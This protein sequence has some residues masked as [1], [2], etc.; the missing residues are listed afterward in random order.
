M[1]YVC[2]LQVVMAVAQL[3]QHCV[4]CMCVCML[5]VV[6]AVAQLYHH[7]APRTEVGTVARALMRLLHNHRSVCLCRDGSMN[8]FIIIHISTGSHVT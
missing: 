3:Y 1:L 4:C 6:M 7:C 2:M 8:E 5:Q